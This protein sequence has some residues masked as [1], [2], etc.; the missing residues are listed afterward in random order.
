MARQIEAQHLF[1]LGQAFALVPGRH[2]GQVGRAG[3]GLFVAAAEEAQLAAAAV[4][5]GRRP[6][7]HR[8]VDGRQQLRA[9][10][11]E[12][13]EGPGLDQRFD[14]RAVDGARIEPFAEVEEAAIGS[15]GGPPGGDGPG[16]RCAAALDGRQSEADLALGHGEL[17]PGTIHVWRQ[18]R[19]A[20][21]RRILQVLDQ[22]VLALEIAAG[23]VAGQERGHELDRVV[24]LEVSRHVG[25]QSVG[26]AVRLVEAVA[27]E[28]LDQPEQLGGL[29]LRHP[30]PV[31]PATNS[32]RNLAIVSSFFLLIALMQL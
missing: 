5:S 6:G 9:A 4:G 7:L 25:D 18:H 22:R 8:P 24:G 29:L 11:T 1:L 20:H 14:R 15:V 27:R 28:L 17:G 2:V 16:R 13:I 23:D 19:N 10:G 26:G 30:L 21:P 3:F 31:R 32:S 12:G